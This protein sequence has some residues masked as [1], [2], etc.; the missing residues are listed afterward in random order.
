VNK[1]KNNPIRSGKVVTG[2]E[3]GR[4]REKSSK[5]QR[6]GMDGLSSS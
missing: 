1:K 6:W 5:V 3:K 4:G 2:R